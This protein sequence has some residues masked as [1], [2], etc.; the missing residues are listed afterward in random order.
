MC[1]NSE[2]S[3]ET[4]QMRRLVWAFAGRLCD[5]YHNLMSWLKWTEKLG[6]YFAPRQNFLMFSPC[7]E[8][9]TSKTIHQKHALPNGVK[10]LRLATESFNLKQTDKETPVSSVLPYF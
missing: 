5:K 4:V 7:L 2:G 10:Y 1:A 3:G 9:W 6:Y 8:S